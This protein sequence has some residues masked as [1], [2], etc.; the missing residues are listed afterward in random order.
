MT[1]LVD[2]TNRPQERAWDGEEGSYWASH[3]DDFDASVRCYDAALLSAADVAPTDHVLDVGCGGGATAIAAA[4]RAHRGSV[5]GIDLSAALLEVARRRAT[6]AGVTNVRL[7]RGD[8]QVHPFPDAAIDVVVSRTGAMFFADPVAA[9][10]N[11]ARGS[12]PDARLALMV[13]QRP[14]RNEWFVSFVSALAAGRALPAPP[15]DAPGPFS[16][17][18]ADRV[19]RVLGAAGWA[20][21]ALDGVEQPMYFGADASSAT[22]FVGGLLDWM[23][24]DLDDHRRRAALDEL[25]TVMAD[26]ETADGVAFRS[27]TWIVTARRA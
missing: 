14:D 26:H 11:L 27:A 13:W 23:V 19:R 10:A 17:A 12:R 4:R 5:A 7:V 6:E 1:A 9:F 24:S 25:H 20:D 21:V 15:P 22:G 16:L 18:D 8:A 3:A 2:P